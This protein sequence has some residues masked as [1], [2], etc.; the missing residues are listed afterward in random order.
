MGSLCTW[1][2]LDVF[3]DKAHMGSEEDAKQDS[4]VRSKESK[5][6][7]ISFELLDQT[8]PESTLDNLVT[9]C[10]KHSFLFKSVSAGFSEG[11]LTSGRSCYS[12][13]LSLNL[14][15]GIAGFKSWLSTHWVWGLRQYFS[16]LGLSSLLKMA[17]TPPD[18]YQ[19]THHSVCHTR[20]L[21]NVFISEHMWIWTNVH[22][23][24][25]S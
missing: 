12:T 19:S 14:D 16:F 3:C 25:C 7:V 13:G 18:T 10:C 23:N 6:L 17:I 21:V 22:V 9:W 5:S 2:S 15:S 8:L 4:D 20:W 11:V 1:E 24:K